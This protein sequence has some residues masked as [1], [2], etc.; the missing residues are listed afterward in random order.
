M[1]KI[2]FLKHIPNICWEDGWM[3]WN[4]FHVRK[5]S[6]WS[7]VAGSWLKAIF[8]WVWHKKK[9]KRWLQETFKHK[10]CDEWKMG[11]SFTCKCVCICSSS[12]KSIMAACYDRKT[13]FANDGARVPDTC[14]LTSVHGRAAQNPLEK[15]AHAQSWHTKIHTNT[16]THIQGAAVASR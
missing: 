2:I 3:C 8:K 16:H 14:R 5:N 6:C 7:W 13:S 15:Q 12:R 11:A 9:K 4:S 10:S 1:Q